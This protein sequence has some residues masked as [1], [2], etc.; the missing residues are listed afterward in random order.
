MPAGSAP[1]GGPPAELAKPGFKAYNAALTWALSQVDEAFPAD[2]VQIDLP[3]TA[4][5]PTAYVG[6]DDVRMEAYRRLAA[7]T[8][9][10]DV[11]DIRA[12]WEDRYGP[13]PA[14]AG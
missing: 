5:L 9:N 13:P 10:E 8:T 1:S 11:D 7:V 12:E 3:V 6:R 14:P 4:H 2:E